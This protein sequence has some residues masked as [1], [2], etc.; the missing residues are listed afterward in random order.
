MVPFLARSLENSSPRSRK[1]QL[2]QRCFYAVWN[3]ILM[4]FRWAYSVFMMTFTILRQVLLVSRL[5]IA[6]RVLSSVLTAAVYGVYCV[7][8]VDSRN[9]PSMAVDRDRTSIVRTRGRS[10]KS[11]IGGVLR[12]STTCSML[13][14]WDR[15]PRSHTF[16]RC[17]RHATR[18]KRP[19]WERYFNPFAV[20]PVG[21][22]RRRK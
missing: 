6:F 14:F 5:Y 13:D 11:N 3:E 19:Q 8:T 9:V 20:L 10:Q 7:T 17:R 1:S 22:F 21:Y 2:I 12:P 16:D 18:G 4:A 15:R